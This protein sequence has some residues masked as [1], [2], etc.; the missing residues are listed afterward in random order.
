M[1]T[2]FLY[3]IWQIETIDI[4]K[5]L[6]QQKTVT[7]CGEKSGS[8]RLVTRVRYILC[9]CVWCVC[10]CVCLCEGAGSD[11]CLP[12]HACVGACQSINAHNLYAYPI[13]HIV[14]LHSDSQNYFG[15][16]C[17]KTLSVLLMHCQMLFI[18]SGLSTLTAALSLKEIKLGCHSFPLDKTTLIPNQ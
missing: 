4:D 10:V 11:S 6:L 2:L 13:D 5:H 9:M 7:Q 1:T 12:M 14:L 17:K 16:H 8:K 18:P 15:D 3:N